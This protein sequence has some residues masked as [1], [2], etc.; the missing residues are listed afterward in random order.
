MVVVKTG[1]VEHIE[2][3]RCRRHDI[4]RN[5]VRLFAFDGA[6]GL[7]V[8]KL[9]LVKLGR[10]AIIHIVLPFLVINCLM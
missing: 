6:I 4:G 1:S 5:L 10:D 7:L 9:S 2:V 8:P 3:S